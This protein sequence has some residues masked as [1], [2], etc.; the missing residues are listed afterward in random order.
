MVPWLKVPAGSITIMISLLRQLH[1]LL[2]G[3]SLKEQQ[4]TEFNQSHYNTKKQFFWILEI[5]LYCNTLLNNRVDF[6]NVMSFDQVSVLVI[7]RCC[8]R[9]SP[10]M[11]PCTGAKSTYLSK[12]KE[13]R[14]L[15]DT[16]YS[17]DEPWFLRTALWQ[18]RSSA[19]LSSLELYTESR[20]VDNCPELSTMTTARTAAEMMDFCHGCGSGN[21]TAF[22]GSSNRFSP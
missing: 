22:Q 6:R 21:G 3:S 20:Y 8:A 14:G 11:A 5:V 19:R 9:A 15:L 18:L 4:N 7:I 10:H 1:V 17:T 13:K 2:W 12:R 16:R